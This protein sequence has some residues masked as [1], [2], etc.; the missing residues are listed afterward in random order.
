MI[1]MDTTTDLKK[2]IHEFIDQADERIL[3]I[4]N[5]IITTEETG[6]EGLSAE[7]KAILDE[8][9]KEHRENP[10]AGK[11]WKEVKQE[12]KKEYGI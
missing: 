11:S 12:L 8:R 5:A 4:I 2:R 10:T 1:T 9:L 3:R 7:H 6:E